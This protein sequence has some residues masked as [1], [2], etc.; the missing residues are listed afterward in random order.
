MADFAVISEA[1]LCRLERFSLRLTQFNL[2]ILQS[3]LG[4]NCIR[5]GYSGSNLVKNALMPSK[6]GL[7]SHYAFS[8][9]FRTMD[10]GPFAAALSRFASGWENAPE[11]GSVRQIAVYGKAL[12]RAFPRASEL[13]PRSSRLRISRIVF[14]KF[15]KSFS[16]QGSHCVSVGYA[17]CCC[18]LRQ[19]S[20]M[21][22]SRRSASA[23][24]PM[25]SGMKRSRSGPTS[26]TEI[27]WR[28]GRHA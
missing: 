16:R 25:P 8:R 12:L 22:W 5:D 7:P 1:I 26:Q 24:P 4:F 21:I 28:I 27:G 23:A 20:S 19:Q 11:A 17:T 6:H 14:Q 3:L 10:T 2:R 13:A 15:C 9:L 18:R